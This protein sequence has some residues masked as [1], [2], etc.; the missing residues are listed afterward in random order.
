[1]S[2]AELATRAD[3]NALRADLGAMDSALRSEISAARIDLTTEVS[4]VHTDLTTAISAIME[5]PPPDA[6]ISVKYQ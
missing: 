4:T 5:Q 6:G 1:M 3:I 2:G